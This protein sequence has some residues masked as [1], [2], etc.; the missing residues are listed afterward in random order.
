MG[1]ATFRFATSS[2][3]GEVTESFLR[4]SLRRFDIGVPFPWDAASPLYELAPLYGI[5]YLIER[6]YVAIRK[7]RNAGRYH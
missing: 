6:F 5:L 7:M 4:L 1:G 2:E 3:A